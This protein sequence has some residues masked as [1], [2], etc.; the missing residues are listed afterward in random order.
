MISTRISPDEQEY[1]II[2]DVLIAR[3]PIEALDDPASL[4][5]QFMV[6]TWAYMNS[7]PIMKPWFRGSPG[8]NKWSNQRAFQIQFRDRRPRFGP[9]LVFM[10]CSNY[11]MLPT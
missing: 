7:F 4:T 8:W 1:F 11:M 3:P 10:F 5:T 6:D 2:R 9:D